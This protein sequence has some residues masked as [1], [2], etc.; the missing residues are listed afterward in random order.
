[1]VWYDNDPR[2]PVA[3]SVPNAESF[4]SLIAGLGGMMNRSGSY[5]DDEN[6]GDLDQETGR[7]DVLYGTHSGTGQVY[8]ITVSASKLPESENIAGTI[9]VR[10]PQIITRDDMLGKVEKLVERGSQEGGERAA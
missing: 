1:M 9:S 2:L 6:G 10:S 8:T 4:V 5:D 7:L 3:F